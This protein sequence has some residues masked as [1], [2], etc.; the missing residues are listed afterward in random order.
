MNREPNGRVDQIS[1]N[2]PSI[3]RQTSTVAGH[4]TSERTSIALKKTQKSKI[5]TSKQKSTYTE[6]ESKAQTPKFEMMKN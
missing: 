5:L 3:E 2:L 1:Q 6:L 4:Q